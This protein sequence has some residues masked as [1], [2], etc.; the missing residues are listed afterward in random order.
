MNESTR[1][2]FLVARETSTNICVPCKLFG[3]NTGSGGC[4]KAVVTAKLGAIPSCQYHLDTFCTNCMCYEP[5]GRGL[6]TAERQDYDQEGQLRP[7]YSLLCYSCRVAAIESHILRLLLDCARGGDVLGVNRRW[8]ITTRYKEYT[9]LAVGQSNLAAK[10][11]VE[12]MFLI[13]HTRWTEFEPLFWDIQILLFKCRI[14]FYQRRIGPSEEDAYH[15]NSV[16][17]EIWAED[18]DTA[19]R[20]FDL[21]SFYSQW[22]HE[23]ELGIYQDVECQEEIE[24]YHIAARSDEFDL[25]RVAFN[26]RLCPSLRN[27]LIDRC[28]RSW[29]L[30][31]VNS[32]LWV[33]PSDE[34]RQLVDPAVVIHSGIADMAAASVCPDSAQADGDAV[35]RAYQEH[36]GRFIAPDKAAEPTGR[37]AFLAP[38]SI[39]QRMDS[40]FS[41]ILAAR[42]MT[43]LNEIVQVYRTVLKDDTQAER[44]CHG[45]SLEDILATLHTENVWTEG[46]MVADV[47][48]KYRAPSAA[49]ESNSSIRSSGDSDQDLPNEPRIEVVQ[50]GTAPAFGVQEGWS[51]HPEEDGVAFSPAQDVSSEP[52]SEPME[53]IERPAKRKGM[54]GASDDGSRASRPRPGSGSTSTSEDSAS[55]ALVTPDES[56]VVSEVHVAES[57]PTSILSVTVGS[58][59]SSPNLG[60]RKSPE[61]DLE[62]EKPV[63][64][65]LALPASPP[66]IPEQ[67]GHP[68]DE[69]ISLDPDMTALNPEDATAL[70]AEDYASPPSHIGS[71]FSS[72]MSSVAEPVVVPYVPPKWA[73][74]GPGA[75]EVI[76]RAWV[77][78]QEVLKD[79]QCRICVRAE[80][81]AVTRMLFE[82]HGQLHIA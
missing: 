58:A 77:A 64:R 57:D 40:L 69:D 39:L 49:R 44:H 68:Y 52:S 51:S 34:V 61:D 29:C 37:S 60:K 16:V 25:N 8:P 28:I 47:V 14:M 3:E 11:A 46:A 1:S 20:D 54:D 42:L 9:Y 17:H 33:M 38:Q 27:T 72:R 36:L 2:W 30:D 22:L 70:D 74:L 76:H 50:S 5:G 26:R 75:K 15:F 19:P 55:T 21:N 81:Q 62:P 45:K 23:M 13:D 18:D 82:E 7:E 67:N 10:S 35:A 65:H 41:D 6:E 4:D 32:G 59:A 43:P 53:D 78:A 12:E 66:D 79:C 80:T 73:E 24:R 56:P 71:E 48:S 63:R 31:R